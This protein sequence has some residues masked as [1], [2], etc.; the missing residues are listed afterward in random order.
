MVKEKI[1]LLLNRYFQGIS[2]SRFSKIIEEIPNGLNFDH[3][4]L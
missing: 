1:N 4:L 2:C 3:I